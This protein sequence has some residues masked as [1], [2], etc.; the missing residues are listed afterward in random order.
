MKKKHRVGFFFLSFTPL[1]GMFA[2]QS[3]ATVV[4]MIVYIIS[5]LSSGAITP[6]QLPSAVAG[7]M[8]SLGD[9]VVIATAVQLVVTLILYRTAFRQKLESPTRYLTWLSIPAI[10]LT[11]AGTEL[12]ISII[13]SGIE[14]YVPSVIEKYA[15]LI[16]QSGLA[17][18]TLVSTIATVILAPVSEEILLRGMT[19]RIFSRVTD[20]F[21]IANIFQALLFGIAHGNIVQGSYAFLLGLLLGYIAHKYRSIYASILAH[22]VFNF[23]GTW[24]NS[25][26][27]TDV[28]DI[29]DI[30]VLTIAAASAVAF[31]VGMI[32]IISDKA[33]VNAAA[34]SSADTAA[35]AKAA[36]VSS[37]VTPVSTGISC[38]NAVP[39]AVVGTPAAF[40]TGTPGTIIEP[41]R[42]GTPTGTVASDAPAAAVSDSAASAPVSD[43]PAEN[44]DGPAQ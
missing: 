11:A 37:I 29:S 21:W 30:K 36:P 44:A 4:Y 26:L 5:Q 19:L 35:A 24:G 7:L 3:A 25:I 22:L 38:G 8:N 1:V 12:L 18:L 33:K 2:V 31:A 20:R 9:I 27:F 17:D 34:L 13:V 42:V 16:E 15:E 28:E 40:V 41:V 32:M 23:T 10:I 6:T 14:Q 39:T 43:G